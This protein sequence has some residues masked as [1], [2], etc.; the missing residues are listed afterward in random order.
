MERALGHSTIMID[1][2]NSNAFDLMQSII[3]YLGRELRVPEYSQ[4]FNMD[5][6]AEATYD[7]QKETEQLF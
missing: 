1:Y 6:E 5:E 7:F 4:I 2:F 3:K